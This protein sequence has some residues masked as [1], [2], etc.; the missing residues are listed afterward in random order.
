MINMNFYI[1]FEATQFTEEIIS[2]GCVAENGNT[3]KC[4]VI[5]SNLKKVTGFITRLTGITREM[6]EQ[7]GHSP[8][9]AFNMLYQ[10]VEE[11]TSEGETPVF[12]CYGH[13]DKAF[14]KNTMKHMQDPDMIL[15]A[16]SVKSLMV[17]YSTTVKNYL[18]TNGLSLKKLVALI[19]HVEEVE[20]DHDALNDAMMLKECFEGLDSLDK[21]VYSDLP[22]TKK[23]SKNKAFEEAYQ[24]LIDENGL[25]EPVRL[26]GHDFTEADKKYLKDLRCTSWGQVPAET[27]SGDADE[28]NYGVKLTH[29]KTGAVK[30]FS[31]P[32]VAAMFFNA[33]ILKARSS[34][35]PKVLNTTMKEMGRNPNNFAGYRCEIVEKKQE[36]S[37]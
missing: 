35:Q 25:L 16:S 4:L 37:E 11:N 30:Y 34:K 9:T 22:K 12:Y 6:I 21:P 17:D 36:V 7:Q 18:S 19:R 1:D 20:Q 28:T 10:F 5:P 14:V 26:Q 3:L 15:F 23:Q 13:M 2:M 24:R 32:W 33:Y 8:D 31:T 27:I 29:I